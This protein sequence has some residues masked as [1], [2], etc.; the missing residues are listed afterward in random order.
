MLLMLLVSSWIRPDSEEPARNI[1]SIEYIIFHLLSP[2][3]VRTGL[4][5]DTDLASTPSVIVI[6]VELQVLG[7]GLG[8]DF[9]FAWDDNNN[10]NNDKNPHLSFLKGTVLGYKEQGI[11]IRDKGQRIRD[12]TQVELDTEDQVLLDYY[13]TILFALIINY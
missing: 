5:W 3:L 7:Q 11:G 4:T 1:L 6:I 8:F 10:N 9:S 2:V 13:L 12:K